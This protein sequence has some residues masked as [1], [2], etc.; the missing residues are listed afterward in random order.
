M[1]DGSNIHRT[2]ARRSGDRSRPTIPAFHEMGCRAGMVERSETFPP[3]EKSVSPNEGER[4]Q[5]LRRLPRLA[6]VDTG[7]EAVADKSSFEDPNAAVDHQVGSV[8][9]DAFRVPVAESVTIR[10]DI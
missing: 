3:D 8:A 1:C 10:F 6:N 5:P 2:A 4:C 9:F 7:I